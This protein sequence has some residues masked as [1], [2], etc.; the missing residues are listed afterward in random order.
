MLLLI[1]VNTGYRKRPS[2]LKQGKGKKLQRCSKQTWIQIPHHTWNHR[3]CC[4]LLLGQCPLESCCTTSQ[5][6]SSLAA[7]E[8]SRAAAH[9]HIP[10]LNPL[11]ISALQKPERMVRRAGFGGS[12]GAPGGWA[13]GTCP[14]HSPQGSKSRPVWPAPYAAGSVQH[15]SS[16]FSNTGRYSK[17]FFLSKP[18]YF[19]R[20]WGV[21]CFFAKQFSIVVQLPNYSDVLKKMQVICHRVLTTLSYL[22]PCSWTSL[23]P[24]YA[25]CW[26]ER[27]KKPRVAVFLK[28]MFFCCRGLSRRWTGAVAQA[29]PWRKP[30]FLNTI[31]RKRFIIVGKN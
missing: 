7:P 19:W 6:V 17:S 2:N 11:P 1:Q 22:F 10:K 18:R 8:R 23:I 28:K 30:R 26:W 27:W 4:S 25:L 12:E 21:S 3:N 15:A 16:C 29:R 24:N 20:H 13:R 31:S 5:R 9:R 14:Y